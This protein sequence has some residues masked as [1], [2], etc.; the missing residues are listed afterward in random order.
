MIEDF[1]DRDFLKS[2]YDD[3]SLSEKFRQFR[4]SISS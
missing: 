4:S 1:F 2:L 3:A